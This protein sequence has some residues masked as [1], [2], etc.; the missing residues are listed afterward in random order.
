MRWFGLAVGHHGCQPDQLVGIHD[1]CRLGRGGLGVFQ[2]PV[3]P[4]RIS[5]SQTQSVMRPDIL[6]VDGQGAVIGGDCLLEPFLALLT[7][8][9]QGPRHRVERRGHLV[10][11][12]KIEAEVEFPLGNSGFQDRL[13]TR[14][15][16]FQRQWTWCFRASLYTLFKIDPTRSA[17]VLIEV[18]G[19][20]FNG[21]QGLLG[22]GNPE[23]STPVTTS[24]TRAA[25][26]AARSEYEPGTVA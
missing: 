2:R 3:S 22:P 17:D 19:A 12:K 18:L 5:E 10:D 4:G 25:G 1:R 14:D 20:E 26:Q 7:L 16:L 23:V 24:T 13:E 21:V 8:D 11:D 9:G 15:R 6:G